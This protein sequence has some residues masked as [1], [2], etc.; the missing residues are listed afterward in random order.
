[1]EDSFPT[2][3]DA[4]FAIH[5]SVMAVCTPIW[6]DSGYNDIIGGIHY[7]WYDWCSV[8]PAAWWYGGSCPGQDDDDVDT[9]QLWTYMAALLY[10][11]NV[12]E[13]LKATRH[14]WNREHLP[15]HKFLNNWIFSDVTNVDVTHSSWLHSPRA[16]TLFRAYHP[17]DTCW[18][19]DTPVHEKRIVSGC[20]F[21]NDFDTTNARYAW[22]LAENEGSAIAAVYHHAHEDMDYQFEVYFYNRLVTLQNDTGIP[23]V[24]CNWDQAIRWS[25][26]WTDSVAPGFIFTD[27]GD[28]I[29]VKLTEKIFNPY[30]FGVTVDPDAADAEKYKRILFAEYDDSTWRYSKSVYPWQ[31]KFAV[32]DTCGN[33]AMDSIGASGLTTIYDVDGL[34]RPVDGGI[35]GKIYD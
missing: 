5:D 27:L 19:H 32:S 29:E 9:T 20:K 21:I 1:V 6:A 35:L 18:Q 34:F 24:L 3:W 16:D 13:I 22:N 25:R 15:M 17:S 2:H 28:S 8:P 12:P 26:A 31:A 7:H 23:F 33:V 4:L 14:G 10:E 11:R 30:P